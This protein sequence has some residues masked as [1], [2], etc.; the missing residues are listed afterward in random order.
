MDKK[1]KESILDFHGKKHIEA[2]GLSYTDIE[3]K[4][5][6][7]LQYR[8]IYS[9]FELNKGKAKVDTAARIAIAMGVSLNDLYSPKDSAWMSVI[10]TPVATEAKEEDSHLQI[11][12]AHLTKDVLSKLAL[13]LIK[14]KHDDLGELC[15]QYAIKANTSEPSKSEGKQNE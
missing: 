2:S 6:H 4:C 7:D 10:P 9:F 3:K 14:D 15:N 13:A 8:T 5:G 12:F 11:I 1:E